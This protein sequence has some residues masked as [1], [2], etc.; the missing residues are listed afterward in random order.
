MTGVIGGD[1]RFETVIGAVTGVMRSAYQLYGR[2]AS[3]PEE[4]ED[5]E[6]EDGPRTG[7][8]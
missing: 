1:R 8:P 5:L 6:V 2:S 7:Q 3:L 4:R